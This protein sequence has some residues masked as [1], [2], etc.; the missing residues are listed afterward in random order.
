MLP[1]RCARTHTPL[2]RR[3]GIPVK[4]V[5][6]TNNEG[7]HPV[8]T[9]SRYRGTAATEGT[10]CRET[11]G[12]MRTTPHDESLQIRICPSCTETRPETESGNPSHQSEGQKE[13]NVYNITWTAHVSCSASQLLTRTAVAH[14]GI[15]PR[16]APASEALDRT[17]AR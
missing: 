12:R 11:L 10:Q 15:C 17:D 13:H 16:P 8:P 14:A 9:P 6:L 3:T 1:P 2:F 7:T 4:R 5:T